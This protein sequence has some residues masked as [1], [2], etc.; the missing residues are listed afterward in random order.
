[1][2]LL[3]KVYSWLRDTVPCEQSN[4]VPGTTQLGVWNP[5]SRS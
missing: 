2:W 1:M 3:T 5:G 4:A